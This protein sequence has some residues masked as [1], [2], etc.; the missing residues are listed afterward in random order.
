MAPDNGQIYRITIGLRHLAGAGLGV[1]PE[2]KVAPGSEEVQRA[3]RIDRGGEG[4]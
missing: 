4:S 3:G 1:V 2:G